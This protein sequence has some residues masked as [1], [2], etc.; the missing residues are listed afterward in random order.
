MFAQDRR[1]DTH[2][3]LAHFEKHRRRS[4]RPGDKAR[5]NLHLA[6]KGGQAHGQDHSNPVTR[7]L[8]KAAELATKP[9]PAKVR[10]I[11]AAIC[12]VEGGALSV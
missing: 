7:A 8:G 5:R 6:D 2:F 4:H 3:E 9:R 1:S 10:E 11:R 12:S